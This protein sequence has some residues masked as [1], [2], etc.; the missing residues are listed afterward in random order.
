[1]K[2]NER[3]GIRFYFYWTKIRVDVSPPQSFIKS[4]DLETVK[5]NLFFNSSRKR[6]K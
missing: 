5:S 3:R 1:M 4:D 6:V 2:K